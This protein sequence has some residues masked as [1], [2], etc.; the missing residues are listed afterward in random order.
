MKLINRLCILICVLIIAA[1][2]IFNTLLVRIELGEVGVLTQQYALPGSP[3]GVVTKDF[4]PGWHRDLGPI[5]S[6]KS[7][8]ATVQTIELAHNNA[9][10]LKSADGYGVNLDLT[11]KFKIKPGEVNKLYTSVGSSMDAAN[12]LVRN[13]ALN[14]VRSAFGKIKT[15]DFYNP[16]VRRQV[17][18]SVNHELGKAL[19]GR[20]IEL[21]DVLIREIIFN[22]GYEKKILLKKLADQEVELN[23][24]MSLAAEKR[25][26]TQ[27]I[28]AEANAMV[29]VIEKEKEG[30]L[31]KM[32]AQTDKQIAEINAEAQKY[33]TQTKAD[34]DLYAAE[35]GAKGVLLLRKSEAE[36]EQ[37]KAA[38]LQGTGGANLVALQ[39]ARNLKLGN[40]TLSTV[41]TDFLNI[42]SMAKMLGAKT[43]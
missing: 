3:K 26:L 11:I 8:D 39:A 4:G 35:L 7:F 16:E 18:Q 32:Q 43:K 24:S 1:I 25:G 9:V 14:T 29:L 34:A 17:T 28:E 20:H 15:E 12:T 31:L 19:G 42:E 22:E 38:A 37:N 2:V 30:E 27:V 36:G 5:H 41:D 23:K 13:E 6:W 33:A 10:E 40:M 21:I